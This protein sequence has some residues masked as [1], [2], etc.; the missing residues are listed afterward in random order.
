MGG[1]RFQ[2]IEPQGAFNVYYY[3]VTYT[4]HNLLF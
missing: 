1:G 2:D 4:N 3:L